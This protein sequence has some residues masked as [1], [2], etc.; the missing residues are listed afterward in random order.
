MV[1]IPTRASNQ[2]KNVA[3]MHRLA[4]VWNAIIAECLSVRLIIVQAQRA[5]VG[6]SLRL[7]L[8]VWDVCLS[9]YN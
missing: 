8:Y 4:Q 5:L 6:L 2:T 7:F 9:V 1:D 3:G